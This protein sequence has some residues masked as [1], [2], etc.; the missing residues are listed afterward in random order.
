MC[1]LLLLL[2]RLVKVR[3]GPGPARHTVLHHDVAAPLRYPSHLT[4]LVRSSDR[5]L[6][7]HPEAHVPS[8]EVARIRVRQRKAGI[9]VSGGCSPGH[10]ADEA[11][12]PPAVR[13]AWHFVPAAPRRVQPACAGH[14]TAR[15]GQSPP[16]DVLVTSSGA[17]DEW[18]SHHDVAID[19]P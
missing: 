12:V 7:I 13:I 11:V 15:P 6:E 19:L 16:G 9:S 2:N 18:V 1:S 10:R 3:L 17:A 14:Q 4:H 5:G 8:I